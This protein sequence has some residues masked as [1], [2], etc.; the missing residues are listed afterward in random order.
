MHNETLWLLASLFTCHWLADYTPL[1]TP[2]MLKAKATGTPWFPIMMHGTTHGVLMGLTVLVFTQDLF[3][4]VFVLTLQG[5]THWAIDTVK[6]RCNVWFPAVKDT[7]KYFHWV[8]FGLD[9]LLHAVVILFIV[10]LVM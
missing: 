7:T 8:V 9:Q 4:S 10:K 1:S 6:G 3:L 5:L 2:S